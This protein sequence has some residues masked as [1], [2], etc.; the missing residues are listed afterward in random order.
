MWLS[1]L[2]IVLPDQIL[3]NGSIAIEN[4]RIAEIVE[5]SVHQADLVAPHLTALPGLVDIRTF[6]YSADLVPYQRNVQ[7]T[8]AVS[9]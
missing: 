2:Q 8:F 9:D 1:G 7:R 4:G 6:E 5:G 3:P